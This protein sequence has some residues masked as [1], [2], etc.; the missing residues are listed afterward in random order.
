MPDTGT[1]LARLIDLPVIS[2]PRRPAVDRG[3]GR[4]N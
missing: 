3:M 2:D 4:W 1:S